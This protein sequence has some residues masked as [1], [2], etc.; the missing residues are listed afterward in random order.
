MMTSFVSCI[1][2]RTQLSKQLVVCGF[3]VIAS[4]YNSPHTSLKTPHDNVL[5]I[6]IYFLCR[7]VD[8]LC[9]FINLIGSLANLICRLLDVVRILGDPICSLVG[10]I[11]CLIDLLCVFVDPPGILV[12]ALL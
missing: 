1:I 9:S 5:G 7:L 12:N 11:R 10:P 2:H 6:F 3:L 8:P 4:A